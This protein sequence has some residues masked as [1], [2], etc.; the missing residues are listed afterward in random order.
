M[1]L[2]TKVPFDVNI[3]SGDIKMNIDIKSGFEL[4]KIIV[5]DGATLKNWKTS[6]DKTYNFTYPIEMKGGT[7]KFTNSMR[8]CE[9]L[10]LQ[11]RARS[12]LIAETTLE[13]LAT[14]WSCRY[15]AEALTSMTTARLWTQ[16][17]TR[18]TSTPML[19]GV[20]MWQ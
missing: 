10:T 7:I 15:Q 12:S 8:S 13:R 1:D 3:L 16:K 11:E 6:P 18:Y 17:E 9:D 19:Q 5:Y 4:P 14:T 2:D 20:Q